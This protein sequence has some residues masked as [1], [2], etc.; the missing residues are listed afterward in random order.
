MAQG[1]VEGSDSERGRAAGARWTE[2]RFKQ[3]FAQNV[4]WGVDRRKA[5]TLIELACPHV[6]AVFA[7]RG[8]RRAALRQ[9]GPTWWTVS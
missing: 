2:E 5:R 1:I 8:P 6:P 7:T 4:R 9:I 3:R